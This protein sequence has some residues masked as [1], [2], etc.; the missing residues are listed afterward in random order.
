MSGYSTSEDDTFVNMRFVKKN[1]KTIINLG[2]AVG[3]I[4]IGYCF[5]KK[6]K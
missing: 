3:I 2:I 5:L 6:K 1:S 4:T